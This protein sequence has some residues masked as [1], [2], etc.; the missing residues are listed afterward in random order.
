MSGSLTGNIHSR[1]IWKPKSRFSVLSTEVWKYW[2]FLKELPAETVLN[3]PKAHY[4]RY[5]QIFWICLLDGNGRWQQAWIGNFFYLS[6]RYIVLIFP[7]KE[8]ILCTSGSGSLCLNEISHLLAKLWS[9]NSA[10]GDAKFSY[11]MVISHPQ[12][13]EPALDGSWL[14]ADQKTALFWLT[15]ILQI[16]VC[17]CAS[18]LN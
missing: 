15:K 8:D 4:S 7:A 14:F 10:N 2:A 5:S 9:R 1:Y 18:F 12:W 6:S 13:K 3:S 16:L 17:S 11:V